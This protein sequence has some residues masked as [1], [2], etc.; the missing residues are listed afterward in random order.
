MLFKSAIVFG[1]TNTVVILGWRW[2]VARVPKSKSDTV[3]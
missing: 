3:G 1:R 2:D